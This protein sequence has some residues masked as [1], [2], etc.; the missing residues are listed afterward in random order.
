MNLVDSDN[1]NWYESMFNDSTNFQNIGL[2]D[3]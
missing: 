2:D 1:N 3:T